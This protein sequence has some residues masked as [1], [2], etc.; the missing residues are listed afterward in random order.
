MGYVLDLIG[1]GRLNRDGGDEEKVE[2]A[3]GEL[4]SYTPESTQLSNMLTRLFRMSLMSSSCR[5]SP[6]IYTHT[7]IRH[8]GIKN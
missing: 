4:R 5:P 3:N 1:Q 8:V 2:H 6:N 7:D